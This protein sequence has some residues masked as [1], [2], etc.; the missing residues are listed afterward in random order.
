M[1]LVAFAL[2]GCV[3]AQSSLT[4]RT[5]VATAT[6]S[7]AASVAALSI[8]NPV[9]TVLKDG[10]RQ[11]RIQSFYIEC[12]AACVVTQK[13]RHT[14]ATTGT[15][16]AAV[17]LQDTLQGFSEVRTNMPQA[18]ASGQIIFKAFSLGAGGSTTI[19][20]DASIGMNQ[21]FAIHTGVMTGV[22]TISIKY[23]ER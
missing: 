21:A 9:S 15:V 7:P 3:F 23:E 1:L 17:G 12:S 18:A 19:P 10:G 11:V 13:I 5:F 22:V 20:V 2:G 8:V 4:S 14:V 6:L 16:I